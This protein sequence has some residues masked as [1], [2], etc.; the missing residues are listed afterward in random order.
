MSHVVSAPRRYRTHE[1]EERAACSGAG[2]SAQHFPA[3]VPKSALPPTLLKHRWRGW[4]PWLEIT[5]KTHESSAEPK[6]L[7]KAGGWGRLGTVLH[8]AKTSTFKKKGVF[9]KTKVAALPT[10]RILKIVEE[11]H[12]K[13][14]ITSVLVLHKAHTSLP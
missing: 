6:R 8:N 10:M 9:S 13:I 5:R 4:V 12:A 7:D 3:S 2:R 11:I 14:Q 1:G